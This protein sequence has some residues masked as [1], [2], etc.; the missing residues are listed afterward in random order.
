MSCCQ[1]IEE[2]AHE[3]LPIPQTPYY[4]Y[5]REVDTQPYFTADQLRTLALQDR[6]HAVELPHGALLIHPKKFYQ[7]TTSRF[8]NLTAKL[9]KQFLLIQRAAERGD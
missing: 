4:Q 3:Y 5:I 2:Y 8:R 6:L 9:K 7:L 1:L